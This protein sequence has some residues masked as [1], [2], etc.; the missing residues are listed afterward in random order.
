MR[1]ERSHESRTRSTI[2]QF[3][4]ARRDAVQFCSGK[5]GTL[6]YSIMS[7]ELYARGLAYVGAT[8]TEGGHRSNEREERQEAASLALRPLPAH[9]LLSSC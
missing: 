4:S 9:L 7:F 1:D 3:S 5:G 2:T 8:G 6:Y